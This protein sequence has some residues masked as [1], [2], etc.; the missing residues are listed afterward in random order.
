MMPAPGTIRPEL[1]DR[2]RSS[3]SSRA[4]GSTT[5]SSPPSTAPCWVWRHRGAAWL[6]TPSGSAGGCQSEEHD[7]RA[8]GG[9]RRPGRVGR[10]PDGDDLATTCSRGSPSRGTPATSGRRS[11]PSP[12]RPSGSRSGPASPPWST[13]PI[14]IAVAHAA[15]TAAVLL[16]GRFFLGVGTGE[17]LNEQPFAERWPRAGERREQMGE[18]IKVVRD[19]WAGDDRQPRRRPLARREPPHLG[20]PGVAS[21]DLRRRLGLSAAPQLAGE[22]GD[23]MIGVT[24][25]ATPVDVF[26]GAG[27]D[28]SRASA[29][30][31]LA[32]GDGWRR[33][34]TNAWEWWP[35]GAV[36]PAALTEL[37]RPEDF[38]AVAGSIERE[39]HRPH[40]RVRDR[41][42]ADRRTPSTATSAPG[43][44]RCTCTRS[45]PTRTGSPTWRGVSCCRT[46]GCSMSDRRLNARLPAARRAPA[47]RR[48][49]SAPRS[50]SPTARSTGG[51][52]TASTPRRCSGG[53]STPAAAR[54]AGVGAEPPTCGRRARR[55]RRAGRR[56]GSAAMQRR[57][58]GRPAA[59]TAGG[60]IL[61]R[62]VRC[63]GRD[64]DP[65]P[66]RC[67]PAAS[68]AALV[69]WR[70]PGT[71]DAGDG[72]RRGPSTDGSTATRWWST[73]TWP[74][75]RRWC[76]FA[77]TSRGRR[78]RHRSGRPRRAG[79]SEAEIDDRRAMARIRLPHQHP[80]RAVGRVARPAGADRPVDRRARR[81]ADDQP[82]RGTRAATASSTTASAGCATRGSPSRRPRQ[83]GHLAAAA[84]VHRVRRR[85]R[86]GRRRSPVT[87]TTG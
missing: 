48:R 75:R 35:N 8:S 11:G 43:T 16:E 70:S 76:G 34:S 30:S 14:P 36:A 24:P 41:R 32:R 31:R 68:R 27:G 81:R 71:D 53:C 22:V 79:S 1:R 10:L 56:C 55:A 3:S 39:R 62:L 61:V 37:A 19:L 50:S 2:A 87:T 80:K 64:G 84:P 17:R 15:A 13:A 4:T 45:G 6:S 59:P 65:D 46:T 44:T 25:D 66:R 72:P 5:C 78:L 49:A 82:P 7:P 51:A 18:A 58:V 23:G 86:G 29:S 47:A 83:L 73:G 67:G 28:G 85:P 74:P 57:A 77:L 21:A 69:R 9:A 54:P 60:S 52:R 38:E 40:R 42:G 12:R 63:R 26:R 33:H 20:P